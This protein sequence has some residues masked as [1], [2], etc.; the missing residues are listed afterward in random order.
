METKT[1]TQIVRIKAAPGEIY[2]ALMDSKKHSEITGDT[3]KI[4]LRRGGQFS[5]FSGYATGQNLELVEDKKIVQSWRASNWPEGHFS[6]VSIELKKMANGTQLKFTQED[7]PDFDYKS[8]A[9][10]WEGYYWQPMKKYLER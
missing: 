7:V 6:K 2:E 4:S 9:Q 10:G 8:V 5:T 1:I 3:A